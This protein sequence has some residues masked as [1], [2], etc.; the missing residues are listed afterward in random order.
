MI[1]AFRAG[2]FAAVFDFPLN[3]PQDQQVLR[4]EAVENAV[5]MAEKEW[6]AKYGKADHQEELD[7]KI[8]DSK[9]EWEEERRQELEQKLDEVAVIMPVMFLCLLKQTSPQILS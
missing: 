5:S 1:T 6:L 7:K 9:N 4:K 3:I 2:T 8:C